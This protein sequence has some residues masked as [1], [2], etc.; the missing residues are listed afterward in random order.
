VEA[1]ISIQNDIAGNISN[2]TSAENV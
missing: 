1:R 2:R